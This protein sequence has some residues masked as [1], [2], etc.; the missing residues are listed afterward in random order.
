MS[1]LRALAVELTGAPLR[2]TIAAA[3][4]LACAAFVNAAAVATSATQRRTPASGRYPQLLVAL[5]TGER[6][7]TTDLDRLDAPTR[8]ELERRV[9]LRAGYVARQP[10]SR[11]RGELAAVDDKKRDLEAF[12]VACA[13]RPE[14]SRTAAAYAATAVLAYEWEG[15][16]DGPF[17]EAEHAERYVARHPRSVLRGPLDVFLLARYRAAFEAASFNGDR[18]AQA[19][20]AERYSVTF[21][22]LGASADAVVRVVAADIDG[23]DQ[24]YIRSADHPRTFRR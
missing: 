1:R 5:Y 12:L 24:V 19:L 23:A 7:A 13:G 20:A 10:I 17:A 15:Y 11:R 18:A 14:V 22:R 3:V 21:T 8:L 16:S 4:L 6:P 2:R 9:T